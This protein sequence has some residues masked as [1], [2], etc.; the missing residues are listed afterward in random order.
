MLLR[1]APAR[2]TSVEAGRRLGMMFMDI[3]EPLLCYP[4]KFEKMHMLS[5]MCRNAREVRTH[6]LSG[7]DHEVCIMFTGHFPTWLEDGK[8]DKGYA[9]MSEL[10]ETFNMVTRNI[11]CYTKFHQ[12]ID[13]AIS[14]EYGTSTLNWPS[15]TSASAAVPRA[16]GSNSY[17]HAGIT[18]ASGA[19]TESRRP[20]GGERDQRRWPRNEERRDCGPFGFRGSA[21]PVNVQQVEVDDDAMLAE[22]GG[23]DADIGADSDWSGKASW[24]DDG[25]MACRIEVYN[26]SSNSNKSDIEMWMLTVVPS[27]EPILLSVTDVMQPHTTQ[28]AAK[29]GPATENA[30]L[31][32]WH[33]PVCASAGGPM[34]LT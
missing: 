14:A 1:Y 13:E 18:A 16:T 29:E 28:G 10:Q 34:V 17:L 7:L 3:Y 31:G 32:P 20:L 26:E 27:P 19:R 4:Q 30:L 21:P 25:P 8:L 2:L 23:T 12:V 24:P 22:T 11:S 15:P 33:I 6:F 9:Y 5:G